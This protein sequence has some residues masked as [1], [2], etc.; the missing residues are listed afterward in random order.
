MYLQQSSGDTMP[1]SASLVWQVCPVSAELQ[2]SFWMSDKGTVSGVVVVETGGVATAEVSGTV[3]TVT[4]FPAVPLLSVHMAEKKTDTKST[5][6][7]IVL[8][9]ILI[10]YNR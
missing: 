8:F 1:R 7:K 2:A 6:I 4:L 10:D 5:V 3:D 9:S